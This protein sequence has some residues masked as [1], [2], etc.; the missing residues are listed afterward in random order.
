MVRRKKAYR[1]VHW[2]LLPRMLKKAPGKEME[3]LLSTTPRDL[4]SREGAED[5]Y[6]AGHDVKLGSLCYLYPKHERLVLL[7]G[8]RCVHPPNVFHME[9]GP[10]L[11]L[12]HVIADARTGQLMS[13]EERDNL[14]EWRKAEVIRKQEAAERKRE[15]EALE[16]KREQEWV[17][18][19]QAM[20]EAAAKAREK[21]AK[22]AAAR[23]AERADVHYG[24]KEAEEA[25][26]PREAR[27][28]TCLE[29]G[30]RVTE[31]V[32][33]QFDGCLC[34]QCFQQPETPPSQPPA[35]HK[36]TPAAGTPAPTQPDDSRPAHKE[37]CCLRCG[38]AT[39][40]WVLH[41][42][43]DDH[44]NGICLCT[45]CQHAGLDFPYDAPA[46]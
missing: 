32:Y 33:E 16:L 6:S 18:E 17:A 45:S 24:H 3:F 8:L 13:A 36:A 22:R 1:Y 39:R 31:W 40:D 28:L 5:L 12:E 38:R 2:V 30:Q 9:R 4:A 41:A 26:R 23:V 27:A 19:L 35:G 34:R 46:L 42:Y 7:R 43:P 10:K 21:Q 25:P 20:K 44:P 14:V 29:C 37:L 11:D 15:T